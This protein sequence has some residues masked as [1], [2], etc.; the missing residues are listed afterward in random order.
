MKRKC[1]CLEFNELSPNLMDRFIREDKLPN[2]RRL[3]QESLVFTTDAEERAPY[4]EPWIQW[5]T[6]Q[7]GL[8]YEQHKVFDLGDGHKLDVPRVWD[9]VGEAGNRVWICGSMNACY[10]RPIDGYILPDPWSTGITPYPDGEFDSYYNFVRTNVQEHTRERT[11]STKADQLKFLS[12]MTSHGM[13]AGTVAVIVKQLLSERGGR[14]RWKRAAVL[15]RLQFDVFASY[16]KKYQ[17]Q[18]ATFFLNSTA[19]FQHLYWRNM[20]P[21]SFAA[22]PS[23]AEQEEYGNAV[24]FGYQQMD[25]LVGKALELLDGDTTLVFLTALS[26]QPCLNYEDTGGKVFYRPEH[27]EDLLRFAEVEGSPVFAPVMSEQFRLH[28]HSEQEA[29]AAAPKLLN[30]HMEGRPVMK[31]RQTGNEIFTGCNVFVR[32]SPDARIQSPA[33]R[34]AHFSELFYNCNL[35]KSGMHHPDGMFWIRTPSRLPERAEAEKVPL[36]QVAPTLLNLMGYE[37]PTF[38]E[39]DPLLALELARN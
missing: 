34:S 8:S 23:A 13:S 33:G 21:S 29:A 20:A 30:L 17:P 26:Q 5:V 11:V 39:L 36:R 22:K 10:R 32:V 16:W 9:I 37:C 1:I 27:I 12:F 15:D 18:F 7:T 14:H 25:A 3:R 6:V 19:H 2:F 31:V 24:L 28:F 35:V 38:M 4:L